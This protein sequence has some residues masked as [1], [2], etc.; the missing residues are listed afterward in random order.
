[1]KRD[2]FG[3]THWS[4]LWLAAE[5]T[6]AGEAALERVCRDYRGPIYAFFRAHHHD[7]EIAQDLTQEFFAENVATRRIFR[8]MDP[9]RGPFRALLITAAKRMLIDF[10]RWQR[11][12]IRGGKI[13]HVS[14]EAGRDVDEAE[15]R[16]LQIA[17]AGLTPDEIFHQ[18]WTLTFLDR[19]RAAMREAYRQRGR[20][21]LF[22]ALEDHL[23][24]RRPSRQGAELAAA[25]GRKPETLRQDKKRLL[26]AYRATLWRELRRTVGSDEAMA[27][28][29]AFLG[30][31]G[32]P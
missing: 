19:V 32:V 4:I 10:G 8:G 15:R 12:E 11:R 20:E 27:D 13:R 6:P 16:Y 25:L 21:A 14:W 1:M 28:E 9:S 30:R 7:P 24:G 18:E 31:R 3:S 29:W 5:D 2:R 17:D 26:A 22:D 23:P